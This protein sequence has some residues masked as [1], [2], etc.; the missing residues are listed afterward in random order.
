VPPLDDAARI[1]AELEQL[2]DAHRREGAGERVIQAALERAWRGSASIM[3]AAA[4]MGVSDG[5]RRRET[6]SY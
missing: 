1:H 4:A 2:L 3:A 6:A 5:E